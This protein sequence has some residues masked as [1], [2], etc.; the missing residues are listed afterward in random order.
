ML[1]T[2]PNTARYY[3]QGMHCSSCELLMKEELAKLSGVTQVNADAITCT[4]ELQFKGSRPTAKQLN[5]LIAEFGY[6]A[7]TGHMPVTAVTLNTNKNLLPAIILAI[8]VG[9]VFLII[10]RLANNLAAGTNASGVLTYLLLGI[11]A[12]LSSCAALIGGLILSLSRDWNLAANKKPLPQLQFNLGRLLSFILLGGALGVAGSALSLSIELTVALVVATSLIMILLG[13]QMLNIFPALNQ[14][15][16]ELPGNLGDKVMHGKNSKAWFSPL[17]IG[18]GTFLLPCGF[19]LTAQAQALS[20]GSFVSGATIMGAF[21]LGTLP[22]LAAIGFSA[23]HFT[24]QKQTSD[25]FLKTAGIVVIIFALYT[26]NNQLNVLGL[27][28]I[29][30]LFN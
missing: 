11:T 26:I 17:L 16:L 25:L 27:V 12:S 4:V 28:S 15:Q 2:N 21:A 20:S 13:L 29:S 6:K 3:I 24:L 18:M 14:L 7:T 30:D 19:T 10:E 5:S 1:N 22:V 9:I 23:R 8:I